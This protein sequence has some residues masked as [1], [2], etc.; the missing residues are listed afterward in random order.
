MI[1]SQKKRK[2]IKHSFFI[3]IFRTCAKFQTKENLV[4][5]YVFECFQ[6]GGHILKELHEF[7]CMM[8]AITNYWKKIVLN[9]ILWIMDW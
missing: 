3:F 1:F 8:G 5:T 6:S 7:L 9:L 4:M 2:V